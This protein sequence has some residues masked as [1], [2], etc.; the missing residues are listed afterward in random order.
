MGF[1]LSSTIGKAAKNGL[2]ERG[3]EFGSMT[4]LG[5]PTSIISIPSGSLVIKKAYKTQKNP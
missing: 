1:G 2:D 5:N 3:N 4:P